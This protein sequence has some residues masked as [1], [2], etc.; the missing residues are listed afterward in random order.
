MKTMQRSG[1]ETI[2]LIKNECSKLAKKEYKIF[3]R[4]KNPLA[5]AQISWICLYKPIV[6]E[7]TNNA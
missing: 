2:Y 7:Q 4:K 5:T 3:L 6:Y 1:D